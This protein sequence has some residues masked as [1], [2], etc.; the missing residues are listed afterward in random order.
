M[1]IRIRW[2][3]ILRQYTG[4][5]GIIDVEG[6][7]VGGCLEFLVT[8]YPYVKQWIFDKKGKLLVLI[9]I[10]DERTIYGSGSLD[11]NVKD[12]DELLLH[13]ILGGG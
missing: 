7:T 8:Q 6:D 3:E 10:N 2:S 11:T 12:G 9:T 5:P 1:R 4:S 13:V